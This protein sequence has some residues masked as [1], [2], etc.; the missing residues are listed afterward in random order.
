MCV[1]S[2]R[3]VCTRSFALCAKIQFL[4][5]ECCAM[6]SITSIDIAFL[7]VPICRATTSPTMSTSHEMAMGDAQQ[8]EKRIFEY[9]EML[10]ARRREPQQRK[11]A[12][13]LANAHKR[14]PDG[15]DAESATS[16][17]N[18][19]FSHD[20]GIQWKPLRLVWRMANKNKFC[21]VFFSSP[22]TVSCRFL[23]WPLST[24]PIVKV[25]L[26]GITNI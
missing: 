8:T 22:S 23:R 3:F 14:M 9:N 12:K 17:E 18:A 5:F 7:T 24:G 19:R 13:Y 16:A 10:C 15:D 25:V 4:F 2:P 21:F 26:L 11:L 1:H 20:Y 6:S